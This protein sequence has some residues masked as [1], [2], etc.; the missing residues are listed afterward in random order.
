MKRITA[1]LLKESIF[2]SDGR[3]LDI[4]AVP[5]INGRNSIVPLG[6]KLD[7]RGMRPEKRVLNQ[8]E[9]HSKEKSMFLITII[10]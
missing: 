9:K 3:F 7:Y 2:Q 8:H 4:I 1:I 6:C 5:C 10:D